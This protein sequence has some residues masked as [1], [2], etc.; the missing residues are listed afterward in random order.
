MCITGNIVV[1]AKDDIFWR[2][3]SRKLSDCGLPATRVR[4][5]GIGVEQVF[6]AAPDVVVID[7]ED[8][9]RSGVQAVQA[10]RSASPRARVIVVA[11]EDSP[12]DVVGL[13]RTH[14]FG[15]FRKP[16]GMHHLLEMIAR[17]LKAT[18]WQDGIEVL[19]IGPNWMS[20]RLRCSLLT[21]ERLLHFF[22]EM[23]SDIPTADRDCLAIAFREMLNNAIEH[24][25]Q[26]DPGETVQ[27]AYYRLS[28]VIIFHIQDPGDGF[29]F[30]DLP[31]AAI[32][33][34]PD[35]P[36]AHQLYRSS[37]GLRAGGLGLLV[38]RSMVDDVLHNAKGN[39]VVLVKYLDS[40]A[41]DV[42]IKAADTQ[43]A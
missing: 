6:Q 28:R 21:A 35:S 1:I 33:N 43:V 14:A 12:A 2:I 34:P 39:E 42:V 29:S 8:L 25:G 15:F 18:G 40:P 31:H 16:L 27:V 23:G 30:T 24:G 5:F 26:L 37:H 22:D 11:G 17:A 13:I 20:L 7:L 32:S 19:S 41:G 38:A 10:V 3:L 36:I 9:G 4:G